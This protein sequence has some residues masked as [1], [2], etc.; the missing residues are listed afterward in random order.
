MKFVKPIVLV[1]FCL[2]LANC[3]LM[4]DIRQTQT[5]SSKPNVAQRS[6]SIP[7]KKHITKP[8]KIIAPDETGDGQKVPPLAPHG[9]IVFLR[10]SVV[11]SAVEARLYD[12]T[13]GQPKYIATSRN[14]T[15]V[16]HKARPGNHIFMLISGDSVDYIAADIKPNLTY[17]SIIKPSMGAWKPSFSLHPIKKRR[18][19]HKSNSPEGY[20]FDDNHIE[21]L[22]SSA[23]PMVQTGGINE[24]TKVDQDVLN[25]HER[26]WAK[27]LDES[28]DRVTPKTLNI[29]DGR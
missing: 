26:Q 14:N 5:K 13:D 8:S 23:A 29:L 17:Y 11:A 21:T 24:S 28:A 4:P 6:S 7:G 16:H 25:K 1:I 27:W 15:Q 9:T 18:A 3:S 10:S 2:L 12:V 22:I 19:N 20:F